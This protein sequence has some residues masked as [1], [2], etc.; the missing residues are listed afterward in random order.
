M[1]MVFLWKEEDVELR[2]LVARMRMERKRMTIASVWNLLYSKK[3]TMYA[4]ESFSAMC[5][6][7]LDWPM[8]AI[9]P[10]SADVT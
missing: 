6:E 4:V 5:Y 2:V 8:N 10:V 7:N 1:T 3:T 9:L